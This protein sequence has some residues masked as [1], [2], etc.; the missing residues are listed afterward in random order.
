MP[1]TMNVVWWITAVELPVFGGLFWLIARLRKDSE[2]AL[3]ALRTRAEAAQAQVRESLAA[4][5]LEVAKTYVSFGTLKDVETRLTDHLLRIERKL[6]C[7]VAD[8]GVR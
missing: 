7:G 5:K 8:G 2:D 1:E 6:D 3:A 4:Y